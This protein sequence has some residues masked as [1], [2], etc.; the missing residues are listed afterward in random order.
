MTAAVTPLDRLALGRRFATIAI[1]AGAAILAARAEG[2]VPRLKRDQSPV[3]DADERA[4]AI[5]LR[6]LARDAP[7]VPVVAEEGVAR[8]AMPRVGDMF[9]FVDALDGTREFVAG[10]DDF[11]VNIALVC[12][13]APIAGAVYAPAV[14]RLWFAGATAFAVDARACD[15]APDFAAAQPI[16]TRA[17]S[18][19]APIALVSRSHRDARVDALLAAWPG[20]ESRPLGSSMKF[21]IVAE[22]QADVYPRFGRTMEWDIAAGDAVLRAAGGVCLDEFG[23]EK[24]YGAA[25]RGFANEG[26]FA[27]GDAAAAARFRATPDS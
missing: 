13:G 26:F 23:E 12:G 11:T 20:I 8:G 19:S 25:E 10:G 7:G 16:R 14:G 18:S 21:C 24:R 22:G 9:I 6:A 27:W 4:E 17:F 3:T 15:P 1:E 5:I 2:C